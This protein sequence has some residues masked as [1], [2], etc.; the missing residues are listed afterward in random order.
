MSRFSVDFD[1]NQEAS[2]L[3]GSMT[4]TETQTDFRDNLQNE[5][6]KMFFG[7]R[8]QGVGIHTCRVFVCGTLLKTENEGIMTANFILHNH[9]K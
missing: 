7:S 9:E 2:A 6:Q 5:A 1:Q 3:Q 4:Q 8:E